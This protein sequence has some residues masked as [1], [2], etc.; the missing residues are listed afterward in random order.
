M[1][2]SPS[3]AAHAAQRPAPHEAPAGTPVV[4]H[5]HPF[6][7]REAAP[8]AAL[9]RLLAEIGAP[10]SGGPSGPGGGPPDVVPLLAAAARPGIRLAAS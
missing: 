2:S 5:G 9:E 7:L 10:A 3:P 1:S 8:A 4:L 6:R